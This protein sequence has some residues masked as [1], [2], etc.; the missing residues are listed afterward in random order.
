V[1]EQPHESHEST[2][3][4]DGLAGAVGRPHAVSGWRMTVPSA[5]GDLFEPV[6]KL[7]QRLP[8][9]PETD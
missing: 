8:K 7:R 2:D 6:L 4:V 5:E 3:V 1:S 9:P